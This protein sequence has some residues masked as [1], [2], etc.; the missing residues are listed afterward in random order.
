[1]TPNLPVSANRQLIDGS[2]LQIQE[3]ILYKEEEE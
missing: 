2:E 3:P 1:M